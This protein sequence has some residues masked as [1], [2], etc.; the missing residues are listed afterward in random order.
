MLVLYYTIYW[1]TVLSLLLLHDN[2]LVRL[3]NLYIHPLYFNILILL[4]LNS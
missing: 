3:F 2:T 1:N 4:Q